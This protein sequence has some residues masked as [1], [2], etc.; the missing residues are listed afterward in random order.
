VASTAQNQKLA[1]MIEALKISFDSNINGIQQV[2]QHTEKNLEGKI[3]TLNQSVVNILN[4]NVIL[5]SYRG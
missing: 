2:I 3:N 1:A 4:Q 5:K